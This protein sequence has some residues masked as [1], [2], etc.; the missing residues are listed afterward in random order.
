MFENEFS[1]QEIKPQAHSAEDV[2]ASASC[3][4]SHKQFIGNFDC[5]RMNEFIHT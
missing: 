5:K 2:T 4:L 1:R 3:S